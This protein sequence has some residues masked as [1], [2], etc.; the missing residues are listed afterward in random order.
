MPACR[1]WFMTTVRSISHGST[2]GRFAKLK[3]A[4]LM[5]DDVRS[6]N[7]LL[8]R[9]ACCTPTV[10]N[11]GAVGPMLYYPDNTIQHAGV[12]LGI[13]GVAGHS[14]INQQRGSGGYVGRAGLEQIF[15]AFTA[16]C[17][18]VRARRSSRSGA[19]MKRWPSLSNDVDLCIRLRNAGWRILWTPQVEHYH[20]R[21]RFHRATR[22]TGTQTGIC[23]RSRFDAEFCG[24]QR[25][26]PIHLTS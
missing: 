4:S 7:A 26:T 23:A 12:T 13:W 20:Q 19:S 3:A 25:S 18:A 16:A 8:A 5:N 21:V 15:H 6:Y 14:F 1:C 11:V 10:E 17:M 22:L 24:A 9:A 2:I